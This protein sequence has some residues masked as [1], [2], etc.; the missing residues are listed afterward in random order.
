[1]IL[2][3]GPYSFLKDYNDG[4]GEEKDL[5]KRQKISVMKALIA[6]LV[7]GDIS[8]AGEGWFTRER[9]HSPD[10]ETSFKSHLCMRRQDRRRLAARFGGVL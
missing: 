6:T 7:A 2:Q 3:R 1:M 5:S 8:M 4:L 10:L 9:N